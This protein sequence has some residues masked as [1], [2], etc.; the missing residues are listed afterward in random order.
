M[1]TGNISLLI[2]SL[3]GEHGF[4]NDRAAFGYVAPFERLQVP[5]SIHAKLSVSSLQTD[6]IEFTPEDS[7]RVIVPNY[8][9]LVLGGMDR[10]KAIRIAVL[11][12]LWIHH[13]NLLQ[14]RSA[15]CTP[16][17]EVDIVPDIDLN[18]FL[19]DDGEIRL[20]DDGDLQPEG[21][22]EELGKILKELDLQQWLTVAP[23]F[24][25]CVAHVFRVRGHHYKDEY[26]G[27][28]EN[29]WKGTTIDLPDKVLTWKEIS[30]TAIHAF[31]VK[32]LE[33]S[34]QFYENRDVLS[35]NLLM[36]RDAVPCG[37]ALVGTAFATLMQLQSA[38]W[39]AT[40]QQRYK[41]QIDGLIEEYKDVSTHGLACHINAG[42]YGLQK[43]EFRTESAAALAPI[44]VGYINSLPKTSAIQQQRALVKHSDT[45]PLM[46]VIMQEFVAATIENSARNK[47]LNAM[48]G[49]VEEEI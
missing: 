38:P 27:L 43:F 14:T 35:T 10:R 2:E 48:L 4:T 42:L 28:Y 49:I 33:R 16:I 12:S 7:I 18:D 17:D 20:D 3:N 22:Y 47:T 11:R 29:T 44:L 39:Y 45:N 34:T 41:T 19:Y 36:R 21:A 25:A 40:L 9:K 13:G 6:E 31:G 46:T 23:L 15:R 24:W 32:A 5:K 26:Q 1:N 37:A 30:R 8:T